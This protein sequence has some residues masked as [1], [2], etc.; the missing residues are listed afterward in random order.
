MKPGVAVTG[1]LDLRGNVNRIAGL[2]GKMVRWVLLGRPG[3]FRFAWLLRATERRLTCVCCGGGGL[4]VAPDGLPL[5]QVRREGAT[6]ASADARGVRRRP[7]PEG[8][9]AA[10]L[11][12]TG[13]GPTPKC[14]WGTM[15]SNPIIIQ[16]SFPPIPH[17]RHATTTTTTMAMSRRSVAPLAAHNSVVWCMWLVL[18]WRR[19]LELRGVT[20]MAE[21]LQAAL[22]GECVGGWS[23]EEEEEEGRHGQYGPRPG[24]PPASQ[25]AASQ[26][27]S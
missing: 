16:D 15:P 24:G 19:E 9:G 11:L 2:R 23:E 4:A 18:L 6:S 8:P 22:L 20:N 7:G 14:R 10:R 21:V 13:V 1:H 27:T 26:P 5:R 25:P 17:R 3:Q 12:R